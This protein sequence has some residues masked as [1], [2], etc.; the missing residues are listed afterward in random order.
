MCTGLRIIFAVL[1]LYLLFGRL[2]LQQKTCEAAGNEFYAGSIQCSVQ[3]PA[4]II[5]RS[6][7]T[8][9]AIRRAADWTSQSAQLVLISGSRLL[10]QSTIA[11]YLLVLAGDLELNP[12][13]VS[14][15]CGL[16]QKGC[17]SNQRA[18]QCDQC[19]RWFHAKCL[20]MSQ[21]EYSRLG[22][23]SLTW[24]CHTCLLPTADL[25]SVSTPVMIASEAT[26]RNN[27]PPV[28]IKSR[29]LKIAHLNI[30]SLLGKLDQLKLLMSS[31]PFD[32]LTL[33]ETWLC[34]DILDSELELPGY[35]CTRMDRSNKRGGG[36]IIYCKDGLVFSTK[37]NLKSPN[38]ALWIQVNRTKCKPLL[39]G[40]V[41]RPP[42]QNV[43]DFLKNL[44]SSLAE[45]ETST[46]IMVLGDFNI[47]FLPTK[48]TVNNSLKRKLLNTVTPFHLHQVINTPTRITEHSETTIDLI[49]TNTQQKLVESGVLHLGLSDHSLVYCVHKSGVPKAAPKTI[50]FRCYKNYDKGSFLADL[51]A[52]P[53]NLVFDNTNVDDSV[54]VWYKLYRNVA[55]SHAPI[56]TLRVRGTSTPW[57]TSSISESM[58]DRDYHHKK[59]RQTKSGYHWD[60]F[61]KLRNSVRRQIDQAKADYYTKLVMDS[62]GNTSQLWKAL[63]QT[64]PDKQSSSISSII[65]DGVTFSAPRDIASAL[66]NHFVSIGMKL[67]A[68]FPS[69]RG[70]TRG[71]SKH[72]ARNCHFSIKEITQD[73]VRRSLKQLKI[74]KATGLDKLSARLLKD[75]A[76]LIT[77]SLT[78]L[79]NS[80]LQSSTFP[81]IWKSAKVTSLH[82]SGDK[83][84]PE[85]YRPISVLPTL[86][87]ILEKAVH[88]QLYAYLEENKLLSSKQ[89]GFRPKSSTSTAVGQF[90]DSVLRS[91]D[92]GMVTGVVFLDLAKA[93]DTVDHQILLQKLGGYGI[94]E[95]SLEWFESYLS[96]RTQVTVHGQ[97]T[98]KPA[99]VPIGVA[100]GSI[101]GPLLFL[102]YINDLPDV[103]QHA[104]ITTYADDTAI[105]CSSSCSKDLELKLNYDLEK[106]CNWLK[107]NHLT[108]N[109]TKSNFMLI[110]SSQKLSSMNDITI[111]ADDKPLDS[112]HSIKYLG[113]TINENLTWEDH[114]DKVCSKIRSKICILTRIKRYLPKVARITFYNAFILPIFDYCDIVWGD[115]GNSSLMRCLQVLQNN[116]ARIILDLP[117]LSSATQALSSLNWKPLS[118]RRSHHRCIFMYKMINNRIG[119]DCQLTCNQDF[120]HYNTRS[121]RNVRIPRA[122]RRWG[123]WTC[124]SVAAKDWNSLDPSIREARS[125]LTF[126][127]RLV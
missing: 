13:P 67:A 113:V 95:T 39:I 81:A 54:A 112:V 70:T 33:S 50:E 99:Q 62:T 74:N 5:K 37:D 27:S 36:V 109:V 11:L 98:S 22:E 111:C 84:T 85:N 1:Y 24:Y 8:N 63:K 19:D 18:I 34:K 48:R 124:P 44:E 20:H 118:E 72:P 114:I 78:K 83:S 69:L 73:F 87:K 82:K 12:G 17:R 42:D 110:G 126:K 28:K 89:F 104:D 14:N 10:K 97:C 55:D 43:D 123:Q 51:Q 86:S 32:I 7:R 16:C 90:S 23:P 68:K 75:S 77:P 58:R 120:H 52:V 65:S 92:K 30:R 47:D 49:F 57:M 115:R 80:S 102:I 116:T 71:I 40:C 59:A 64:L 41:Y 9:G 76:D 56:K 127:S 108:L 96:A 3:T 103:L 122:K 31:K 66:N 121:K 105:Y 125:L 38:E 4:G 35:T 61:R 91:M 2:K 101:L 100:Q 94:S 106:V 117:A 79:F 29:G 46:E 88:Q 25:N 60:M 53:W 119:Y 45:V 26:P 15:P 6:P 93:F 21:E 107:D